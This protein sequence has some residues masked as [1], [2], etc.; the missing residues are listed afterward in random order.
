MPPP[1]VTPNTPLPPFPARAPPL[2]THI[3]IAIDTDATEAHVAAIV[4][5]ALARDPWF[6]A[7]RDPQ[8]VTT[9][10]TVE[11]PQTTFR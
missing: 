2:A 9:A 6:L 8:T 10:V 7:L 11:P 4:E 5:T 3:S 1:P